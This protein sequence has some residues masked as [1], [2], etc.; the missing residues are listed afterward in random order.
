MGKAGVRFAAA[1][2]VLDR[3][4]DVDVQNHVFAGCRLHPATKANA[5]GTHTCSTHP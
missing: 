5:A 2:S 3:P 1:F 4:A